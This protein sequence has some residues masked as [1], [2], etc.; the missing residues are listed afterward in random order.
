MWS[1]SET[2]IS[3][4][5]LH[6]NNTWHIGPLNSILHCR[7]MILFDT[8][9]H[10]I[11]QNIITNQDLRRMT[12]GGLFQRLYSGRQK[13]V[14]LSKRYF[15]QPHIP[16]FHISEHIYEK[17]YNLD[18]EDW[19]SATW[20]KSDKRKS[21]L[22]ACRGVYSELAEGF[23]LNLPWGLTWVCRRAKKRAVT[24]GLLLPYVYDSC[25]FTYVPVGFPRLLTANH[26]ARCDPSP[27]QDQKRLIMLKT[28]I[29]RKN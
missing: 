28:I 17:R 8:Y 18:K 7:A 15:L 23:I 11:C 26:Y 12:S 27:K 13:N 25:L 22:W 6:R 19:Q 3:W 2:K 29:E 9:F 10:S 24:L 14:S 21:L 5:P 4:R 1:S 16:Q 20:C